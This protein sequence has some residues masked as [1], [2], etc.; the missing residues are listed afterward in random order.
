MKYSDIRD[1]HWI[2]QK[3]VL[4]EDFNINLDTSP[5][6]Y[7]KTIIYIE[8]SA[9][10][11]FFLQKTFLTPNF[12]TLIYALL[13]VCGGILIGSAQS[14]LVLVGVLIFFFKSVIDWSD[15]LLARIRKKT[16]ELGS[17]LD[18]WAGF[19]GYYSFIIGLGLYLYNT[20]N[21]NH[22]L[23]LILILLSLRVLDLKV[24][25]YISCILKVMEKNFSIFKKKIINKKIKSIPK[26]IFLS[27][28][29]D[30]LDDRSRTIDL[31]SFL[32]LLDIFYKEIF[33]LNY[34]FYA[35]I[36]K[37]IIIYFGNFYIIF[38]KSYISNLNLKTK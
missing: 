7:F 22:F 8:L 19:V 26:N 23:Y 27:L 14:E 28:I 32:I 4:K 17:L 6:T 33:I 29:K 10:L 35:F 5:Y 30:S 2:R 12:I 38:F 16:S 1:M 37:S 34:I 36:V 21:E 11:V 9:I 15:G 18:E 25:F 20:T 24:F 31:I 13:G 3:K